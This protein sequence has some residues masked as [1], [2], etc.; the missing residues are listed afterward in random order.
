ML[1]SK[2]VTYEI[3]SGFE[4][5]QIVLESDTER[6]TNRM[7]ASKGVTYEISS[8][9]ELLQIISESDTERCANRT[10]ASKEVNYEIS[11]Q[12][13]REMKPSLQGSGNL[14]LKSKW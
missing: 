4:L 7:L 8:G 13:E 3:S 5:L 14:A 2:G 1:A 6:C 10:L 9:F 12:L 11:C